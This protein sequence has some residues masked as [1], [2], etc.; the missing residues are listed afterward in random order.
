MK[1]T[2][3][4]V[5]GKKTVLEVEPSLTIGGLKAKVQEQNGADPAR[6]KLIHKGKVLKDDDTIE[7]TGVTEA[8][9]FVSML[10]AAP[11]VRSFGWVVV[12]WDGEG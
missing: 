11:K 5:G 3:K 2:I 7:S 1:L 12:V 10:T 6:Q 8:D 4:D 9:F